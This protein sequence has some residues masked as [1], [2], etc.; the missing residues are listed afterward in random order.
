[1]LPDTIIA[2]NEKTDVA[3][4]RRAALELARLP[5]DRAGALSLLVTEAATNIL[6]HAGSGHIVVRRIGDAEVEM[7]ALDKGPGLANPAR[8]FEDGYST[9]G[10]PWFW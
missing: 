2:V 9:A 4:A 7:I 6:K 10:S 5:D 8:S 1:M 3:A